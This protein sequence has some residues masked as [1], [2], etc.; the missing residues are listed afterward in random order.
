ML[1]REC[2]IISGPAF[3][4]RLNAALD[5]QPSAEL[6]RHISLAQLRKAG[7]FFS[8][9]TL[10]QLAVRP[11]VRS[12]GKDSVIL[13]PACGAG[14][15]LIASARHLAIAGSPHEVLTRW[16]EQLAGSDLYKVF[17]RATQI[18]LLLAAYSR[19]VR[20][21]SDG[22]ETGTYFSHVK[23]GSGIEDVTAIERST[24][25]VLNPPY[26]YTIAP[27]D[28]EWAEG[29]INKAALFLET[30]VRNA[31]PGTTIV[32]IL[33]DVLRSGT[34]YH[35]WRQSILRHASIERLALHGQ[36]D[37]LTDVHVFLLQL[38]VTGANMAVLAP[39]TMQT[40]EKTPRMSDV[41]EVRVGPVVPHRDLK[42]GPL[43]EF[44]C[45]KTAQRWDTL[46]QLRG[47]RRYSGRVFAPPFV[48]VRR[49][50]RPGDLHR[51]VATVIACD[52]PVAVENHLLVLVPKDGS[53]TTCQRIM[54]ALRDG[55]TTQWLDGRI[56][57]RHLT[58]GALGSVPV[59]TA[60]NT[61]AQSS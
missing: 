47:R 4:S 15:L 61:D 34:R 41:A 13:D 57:C 31:R 55:R 40:I 48:V 59:W 24:H 29:R 45:A 27:A 21:P 12:L 14:D 18:R 56:R 3:D 51:A 53:L 46:S 39:S 28:C 25:I 33:P 23:Q 5:G 37:A 20:I 1:A 7:A 44:I 54:I 32:A 50:S 11:I 10:A 6:R 17:V 16:G 42:K 9:S 60:H 35:A 8:G 36:F 49:T 22:I 19:G 38:A 2:G 52:K 43:R 30:C 58:V 26:A